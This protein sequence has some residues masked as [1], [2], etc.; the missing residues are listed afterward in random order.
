ML[1]SFFALGVNMK[2][3]D[4]TDTSGTTEHNKPHFIEQL[5]F[6][7]AQK[8][9]IKQIRKDTTGGKERHAKILAVLTPEQRAHRIFKRRDNASTWGL[10]EVL[11][12]FWRP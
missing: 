3:Q 9:Q 2:A 7:D 10:L 6:T 12:E 1:L 8:E 11:P 5:G 4:A